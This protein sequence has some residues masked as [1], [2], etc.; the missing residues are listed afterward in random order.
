MN[1]V[2]NQFT[3]SCFSPYQWLSGS[4][5]YRIVGLLSQWRQGSLLLKWGEPLG[6]LLISIVFIFGPFITTSLIGVWLMALAGYWGI[7]TISDKGPPGVT[8]IHLMVILYWAIAT[9]AVAFS[10]VKTIALSGLI[11]LS[12]YLLFFVICA[13]I[14]R[15]PRLTNWLITIVLLIGL[16]VSSYGVRQNF[17]GVEQLA[18]WNDPTSEL[19]QATR[20]YSYLGN[21]NLLCAYLFPAIALSIGA[22]FVWRGWLPKTLAVTMVLTNSACLYFTGSRGG[23]IGMIALLV[24]F[25]LL[26]FLWFWELIPNFWRKWLLTL[27]LGGFTGF[28]LVAVMTVEPLRLRVMSIFA[29][30]EDSSNNF[31]MNVW[32]GVIDMIRDYPL[33]GIG[34]GNG[35]FNIVY[36]RYMSPKYSALSAYSIFLETAV[37]MG[38][39]GLG[40]F[41]WLIVVTL[42]QG[43]QQMQRLRFK[44]NTQGFWLIAA[45]AAMAGILAQGLVDT[46]WYRPQVNTLWWFVVALIASQYQFQTKEQAIK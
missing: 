6:A 16:V 37:E 5:L 39:I 2:W 29:G 13:R 46:V 36:P 11:K 45:V 26:L 43:V 20:V 24:V 44:H 19:A 15:S 23:W 41:L 18:T 27:V 38:L 42:N 4:Y 1:S 3:L 31:R 30:R 35:A 17:F 12:L 40:I 25:M 14:L 10:P 28:I 8:P 33:T 9:I 32:M 22:V 21:P 34:P 7:L